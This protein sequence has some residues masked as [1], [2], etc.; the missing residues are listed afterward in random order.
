MFV[1]RAAPDR[2]RRSATP[3][4][5]RCR[6]CA[7]RFSAS[8]PSQKRRDVVLVVGS[9][10]LQAADGHR[11]RAR[12]VLMRGRLAQ[13]DIAFLDAAAAA[14]RLAWAIAGAAEDAGEYVRF[15]VDHVGIAVAARGDQAD[16]FGDRGVGRAGPLTID[17]FMEVIGVRARYQSVS[18]KTP[19]QVPPHVV[20]FIVYFC[21]RRTGRKVS[22]IL[23]L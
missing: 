19:L 2:A 12:S 8:A 14:C 23:R 11:L 15:P 5:R 22:Q 13:L 4:R 9:D 10:T 20:V 17:D 6:R 21:P 16:V 3:G 7:C 1:T 18:N